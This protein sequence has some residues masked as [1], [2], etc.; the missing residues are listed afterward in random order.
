MSWH[1]ALYL[2]ALIIDAEIYGQLAEIL[3]S[4]MHKYNRFAPSS[5]T[6]KLMLHFSLPFLSI[7]IRGSTAGF[8]L[9]GL[10]P[11]SKQASLI[12]A[13]S[14]ALGLALQ[15]LMQ[16]LRGKD[17]NIPTP[18][19]KLAKVNSLAD[20]ICL[21]AYAGGILKHPFLL[22]NLFTHKTDAKNPSTFNN[23]GE[24]LVIPAGLGSDYGQRQMLW[25]AVQE[26]LILSLP[27][28]K[29]L[30]SILYNEYKKHFIPSIDASK[31]YSDCGACFGC[32]LK[33]HV[34]WSPKQ[35][36]TKHPVCHWCRETKFAKMSRCPFTC[37]SPPETK[38][39]DE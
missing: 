31:L 15:H 19:M 18:L 22:L 9:L 16:C 38:I 21:M 17:I 8:D 32:G 6:I 29:P 2:D 5:Q 7:M 12:A 11:R 10:N 37:S 3:I 20:W 30:W 14:F 24:Y 35:A 33:E 39:V 13:V 36:C 26:C 1:K 34:Y 27:I 28:V 4:I 25:Q 23:A